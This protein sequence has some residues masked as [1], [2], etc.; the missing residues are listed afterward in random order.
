MSRT[1]LINIELEYAFLKIPGNLYEMNNSLK[2]NSDLF[3]TSASLKKL[4]IWKIILH[5]RVNVKN[6]QSKSVFQ[7]DILK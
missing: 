4:K 3:L 5:L 2:S 6:L 7:R 1:Q